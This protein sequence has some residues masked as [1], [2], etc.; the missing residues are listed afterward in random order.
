MNGT[1][2]ASWLSTSA[3]TTKIERTWVSRRTRPPL[4]VTLFS[5]AEGAED[6]VQNVIGGGR[7]GD[8]IERAYGHAI[9]VLSGGIAPNRA[10]HSIE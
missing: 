9:D 7:A 6:Q 3:T 2:G 5:N 8:G 10:F 1:S 4:E